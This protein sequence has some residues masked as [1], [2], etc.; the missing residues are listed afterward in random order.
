MLMIVTLHFLG[1][2]GV[3]NAPLD[4]TRHIFGWAIE[5]VCIVA[6]NCYVLISG[7]FLETVEPGVGVRPI[8]PFC[9]DTM[10]RT[11]PLSTLII[12]GVQHC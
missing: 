2:G 8:R 10:L 4:S 6:V 12:K 1:K 9:W 7:Y 3:L 11:G 5:S